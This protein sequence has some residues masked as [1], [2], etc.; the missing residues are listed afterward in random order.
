MKKKIKVFNDETKIINLE[1]ADSEDISNIIAFCGS[2]DEII[3][4]YKDEIEIKLTCGQT[5]EEVKK[6]YE[7]NFIH[8]LRDDYAYW[9]MEAIHS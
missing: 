1:V 6:V 2:E 8:I 3:G 7:T 5:F 4:Y 9:R